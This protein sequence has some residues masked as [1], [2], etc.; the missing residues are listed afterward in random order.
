MSSLGSLSHTHCTSQVRSSCSKLYAQQ[1]LCVCLCADRSHSKLYAQQVEEIHKNL[2]DYVKN[3]ELEITDR[4]RLLDLLEQS[5]VFYDV[6]YGEAK[7][8]ANVCT[9]IVICIRI[10]HCHDVP[11]N[12]C[13]LLLS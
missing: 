13:V 11:V 5:E 8:V 7:I 2:D 6:Q 12:L 10:S 3:V 9:D 4:Q 1:V